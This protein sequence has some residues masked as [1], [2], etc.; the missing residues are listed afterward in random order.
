MALMRDYTLGHT[1]HVGLVVNT[2]WDLSDT[3][4]NC[5]E[6]VHTTISQLPVL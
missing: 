5:T 3:D 2:L 4:A 1:S 6:K